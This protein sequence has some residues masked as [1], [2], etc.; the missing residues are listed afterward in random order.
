MSE[1]IMFELAVPEGKINGYGGIKFKAL[2]D[3]EQAND[4]TIQKLKSITSEAKQGGRRR[5]RKTKVK[6]KKRANRRR[7][8]RYQH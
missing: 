3:G 2:Q 4:D 6:S 1:P 5:K 8:T 7:R